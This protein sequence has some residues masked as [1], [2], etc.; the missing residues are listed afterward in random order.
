[1][2][3]RAGEGLGRGGAFLLVSPPLGPLPARPSLGE[4]GKLD[5]ALQ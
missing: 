2:E 1:M 3:E 5:A 4:D